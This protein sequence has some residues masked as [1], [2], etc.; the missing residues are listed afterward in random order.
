MME[1]LK[2]FPYASNIDQSHGCQRIVPPIESSQVGASG[3]DYGGGEGTFG[4]DVGIQ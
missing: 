3:N 2:H 4:G 1:T